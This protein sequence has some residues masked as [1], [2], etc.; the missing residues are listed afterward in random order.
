MPIK[1]T[2]ED[3]V[4]KREEMPYLLSMHNIPKCPTMIE[5]CSF[6]NGSLMLD[7]KKPEVKTVIRVSR[8]KAKIGYW[9]CKNCELTLPKSMFPEDTLP[10]GYKKCNHCR[11]AK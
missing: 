11:K 8:E 3:G 4:I 10:G 6:G 5:L 9:K 7:L 2:C 1:V